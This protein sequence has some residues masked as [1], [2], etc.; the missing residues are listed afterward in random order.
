MIFKDENREEQW[1][2][3]EKS[4]INE[5]KKEK[6]IK[7]KEGRKKGTNN[8]IKKGSSKTYLFHDI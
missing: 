8:E 3:E 6:S 7:M 2:I 1:E 4:M 5:G